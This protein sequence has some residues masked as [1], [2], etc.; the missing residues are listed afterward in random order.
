MRIKEM[1]VNISHPYRIIIH[2]DK[3]EFI[4]WD[5]IDEMVGEPVSDEFFN[6]YLDIF[7]D[8]IQQKKEN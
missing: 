8:E 4:I 5:I 6:Y 7:Y 2:C 3:E 1:K